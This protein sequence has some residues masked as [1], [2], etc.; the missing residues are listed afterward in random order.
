MDPAATAP[1]PSVNDA[2]R[3]LEEYQQR[4]TRLRREMEQAVGSRRT[5]IINELQNMRYEGF[6]LQQAAAGV[7]E[8]I[9]PRV[10]DHNPA[11]GTANLQNLRR[12]LADI[13]RQ[14]QQRTQTP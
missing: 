11:P 5:E 3:Q 1:A 8:S 6:R 14:L 9:A 7:V 4:V 2:R 13:E 10:S 12:E